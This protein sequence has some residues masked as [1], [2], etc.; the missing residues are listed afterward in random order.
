MSEVTEINL[1][2]GNIIAIAG[3]SLTV[4]V[5]GGG[6]AANWMKVKVHNAVLEERIKAVHEDYLKLCV[7]IDKER[8]RNDSHYNV[9]YSKLERMSGVLNTITR[10]LDRK[11]DKR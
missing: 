8:V 7:A 10:K 9:L 11:V 4:I 2:I 5:T 6:L 3:V 1:S